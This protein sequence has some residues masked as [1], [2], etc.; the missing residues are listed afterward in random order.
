MRGEKWHVVV[1]GR[2]GPRCEAL[3]AGDLSWSP[4]SRHFAYLAERG[5]GSRLFPDGSEG[6]A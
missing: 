4:D 3:E 6:V 5:G 1:D 2:A